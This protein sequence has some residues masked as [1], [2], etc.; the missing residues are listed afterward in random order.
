[1]VINLT[2]PQSPLKVTLLLETLTSGQI[3]ASIFEFPQCR[4][5][6][7]TRET[8]IAQLQSTF[9]ERLSHIEAISWDVPF[10]ALEPNWKQFAGVFRDDPDF[11][12]IM[13]TIRAERT[14]NDDSEV[15]PSYYL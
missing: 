10:Q 12:A 7:E 13:E 8:A 5:E 15:D 1:M 9:L 4:V 3:A 6:A 2:V 11:T 14:S